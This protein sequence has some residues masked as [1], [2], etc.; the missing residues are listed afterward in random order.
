MANLTGEVNY[1]IQRCLEFPNII[2]VP[3]QSAHVT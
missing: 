2:R 3:N 1:N